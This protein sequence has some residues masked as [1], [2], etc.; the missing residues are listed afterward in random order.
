MRVIFGADC[1]SLPKQRAAAQKES[2]LAQF[3]VLEHER[4]AHLALFWP[5]IEA[6]GHRIRVVRVDKEPLPAFDGIDA[7]WILGGAMDV[8]EEDKHPW[9]IAEKAFIRQAIRDRRIP[10][11]G[12]CLGHQL[13]AEALGGAC[14]RGGAEIGVLDVA[15]TGASPFLAGLPDPFSVLVW[16]GVEV[17]QPPV[18]ARVVAATPDC[19]VHAIEYGPTAFSVQSHPEVESATIREWAALPG[20]QAV[21][22]DKLGPDGAE[23]LTAQVDARAPDLAA[24]ARVFFDNWCRCAGI[25]QGAPA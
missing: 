25:P 20:A 3:V 2:S 4:S 1:H 14:A 13:M 9:L 10:A 8:F 22:T 5:M 6:A 23:D 12:I 24:N 18:N 16:H 21:L 17:T 11:F 7:L 19:A 15:V